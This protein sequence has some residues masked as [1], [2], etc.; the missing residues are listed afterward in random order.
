M[1]PSTP[2]APT[3]LDRLMPSWDVHEVHTTRI[4]ATPQRVHRALFEV[5]AGDVWLFQSLMALRGLHRRGAGGSR[6]LIEG[7]REGGFAL[8][9]DEPGREV[10][11]GVMGQFWRLRDRRL[12]PIASPAEFMSFAEPGFARAAMSFLIEPLDGE[13]CRVTTETRISATDVA[14]RRAFRAYWIVVHAGSAFIRLMWL[15]ALKRRAEHGAAAPQ[16]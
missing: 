14:A 12:R 10:V 3:W 5:T 1:P 15:R 7:A 2:A 11:L 4:R 8:L 16:K 9:A 6:P 13:T